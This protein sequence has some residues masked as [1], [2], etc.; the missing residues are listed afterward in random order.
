ML[1][2]IVICDFEMHMDPPILIRRPELILIS[3]KR[4]NLVF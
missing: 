4:K 3:K 1:I 2:I